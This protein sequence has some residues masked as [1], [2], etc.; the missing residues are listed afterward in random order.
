MRRRR[1]APPHRI[2]HAVLWM[3][4]LLTWLL[5]FLIWLLPYAPWAYARVPPPRDACQSMP[6]SRNIS[7]QGHAIGAAS[8]RSMGATKMRGR[9]S[10]RWRAARPRYCHRARDSDRRAPECFAGGGRAGSGA[11]WCSQ[12]HHR[13]ECAGLGA[14]GFRRRWP[15]IVG[16]A[17]ISGGNAPHR[18]GALPGHRQGRARL[19]LPRLIGG[20][21]WLLRR[22]GSGLRTVPPRHPGP[23]PTRA[24]QLMRVPSAVSSRVPPAGSLPI[25]C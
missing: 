13:A 22:T 8:A 23:I 4:P 3:L 10:D 11:P 15:G 21:P 12:P 2:C 7:G 17:G 5:P 19:R 18:P 16:A 6:D 14:A 25:G 20:G 9:V 1:S 24:E